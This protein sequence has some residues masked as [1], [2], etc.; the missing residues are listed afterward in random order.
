MHFYLGFKRRQTSRCGFPKV[1]N[2]K[3][4][5]P[6]IEKIVHQHFSDWSLG[7]SEVFERKNEE[8]WRMS[9]RTDSRR[10]KVVL[11]HQ[12]SGMKDFPVWRQCI[13]KRDL[14]ECLQKRCNMI[15]TFL[16]EG[17]SGSVVLYFL[18]SGYLFRGNASQKRIAVINCRKDAW[19][20]KFNSC[21]C[22]KERTNRTDLVEF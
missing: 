10:G 22:G 21:L 13:L 18:Q 12:N 9:M 5:E 1:V 3:W 6:S 19:A 11:C 14:M 2:S 16:T 20:S 15:M 7:R 4:V 17:Q 8:I